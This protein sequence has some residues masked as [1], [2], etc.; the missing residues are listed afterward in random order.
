[1]NELREERHTALDEFAKMSGGEL[2]PPVGSRAIEP[3]GGPLSVA[4]GAMAVAVYRDESR[5][6]TKLKAL[7]AAAGQDWYYRFPVK[8][9]RTGK[10]DWIE[11]PSIK[12]A[13][14]LARIY[15]NCETDVRVQD[16]G[17]NWV[18]YARFMDIETGYSLTRPFQQRKSAGKIGGGDDARRLD[19]AFQIGA[20]KAIR[21][22]VVNALQTFSDFAFE[23]ARNALVD[24]IGADLENYRV[25]TAERVASRVDIKRVEAVVGRVVADWLAPDIARV[26]AM[27][28]A[29]A[30]G[31]ATIDE[32]FPSLGGDKT[33]SSSDALKAFGASD[34]SPAG[35]T[36]A[37]PRSQPRGKASPKSPAG[38]T[39]VSSDPETGEI[40]TKLAELTRRVA[41]ATDEAGVNEVWEQM[42]LDHH[43]N[44]DPFGRRE[45]WKVCTDKIA[46]LNGEPS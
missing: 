45:A 23:E 36:Q 32:T 40:E 13:N 7:A 14:D 5:V 31:M 35:D 30:D 12:L 34:Q 18:F 27:M 17:E 4:H 25:K 20:S 15:G 42:G 21:N 3:I 37:N 46:T 38:D 33:D 39:Q 1:M 8:N 22:V 2:S 16:L 9:N 6:L 43:F 44:D 19:I 28:K 26:V 10:T 11:G 29:V 41:A 24:R